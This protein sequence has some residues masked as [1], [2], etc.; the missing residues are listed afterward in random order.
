MAEVDYAGVMKILKNKTPWRQLEDI[1]KEVIT[2]F[3]SF[4]L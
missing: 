3:T 1:P 4:S 2:S